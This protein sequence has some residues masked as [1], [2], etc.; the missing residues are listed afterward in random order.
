MGALVHSQYL[1]KARPWE[2]KCAIYFDIFNIE[3]SRVK[4]DLRNIDIIKVSPLLIDGYRY[5]LNNISRYSY[6]FYNLKSNNNIYLK[7][8]NLIFYDFCW[9]KIKNFLQF[10][11]FFTILNSIK[12]NLKHFINIYNLNL[13]DFRVIKNFEYFFQLF[14]VENADLLNVKFLQN[15]SKQNFGYIQNNQSI[16]K[17]IDLKYINVLNYCFFDKNLQLNYLN[18]DL[19]NLKTINFQIFNTL[20]INILHQLKKQKKIFNIIKFLLFDI[21]FIKIFFIDIHINKNFLNKLIIY[22]NIYEYLNNL[23]ITIKHFFKFYI[24]YNNIYKVN[25]TN[26]L[27]K[28]SGI[29]FFNNLLNYNL[30]YLGNLNFMTHIKTNYCIKEFIFFYDNSSFINWFE[31]LKYK[32]IAKKIFTINYSINNNLLLGLTLPAKNILNK[33]NNIYINS[34]GKVIVN[35]ALFILKNIKGFNFIFTQILL[36]KKF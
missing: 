30:N 26:L 28:K 1:Y 13:F 25:F 32:N 31:F 8:N 15:F 2:Q 35:N 17:K 24:N 20:K 16:L 6:N 34:F 23:D 11:F 21:F 7:F 14:F 29:I 12:I 36:K 5:W 33:N 4:I 10:V 19:N 18:L 3:M 22:F 9:F 27:S